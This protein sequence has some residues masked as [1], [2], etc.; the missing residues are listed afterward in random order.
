MDEE[1][2]FEVFGFAGGVGLAEERID[3]VSAAAVDDGAG[4][5]EEGSAECWV[6]VGGLMGE[7]AV[8]P[9]LEELGVEVFCAAGCAGSANAGRVRAVAAVAESC[10]ISRRVRVSFGIE[11]ILEHWFGFRTMVGFETTAKAGPPPSA[12]DDS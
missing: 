1:G 10:S 4:G 7:E 6:G 12:K 8:A 9:G 5:A 3:G 2:G 11:G